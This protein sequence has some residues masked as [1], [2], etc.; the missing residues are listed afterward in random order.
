MWLYND[1]STF[2]APYI[3]NNME[4]F[5]KIVQIRFLSGVY[6][7]FYQSASDTLWKEDKDAKWIIDVS[8]WD[9]ETEYFAD[10]K[11]EKTKIVFDL[12]QFESIDEAVRYAIDWVLA[13]PQRDLGAAITS[14]GQYK[15]LAA[16]IRVDAPYSAAY[17]LPAYVRPWHPRDLSA[18]ARLYGNGPAWGPYQYR[19]FP[20]YIKDTHPQTDNLSATIKI[21]GPLSV[22]ID[23]PEEEQHPP[24]P[25]FARLMFNDY[26]YVFPPATP[27]EGK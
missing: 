5:S 22:H 12:T 14:V 7:Y 11:D 16:R 2:T 21:W 3:Y 23:F 18:R 1:L 25:N 15:E 8:S 13:F 19:D 6:D 27:G 9:E 20:S 26:N 24:D 10:K 17:N 4:L